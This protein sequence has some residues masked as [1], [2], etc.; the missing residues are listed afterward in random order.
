LVIAA[1]EPEEIAKPRKPPPVS[2]ES[3]RSRFTSR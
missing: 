2:T 3:L 1:E